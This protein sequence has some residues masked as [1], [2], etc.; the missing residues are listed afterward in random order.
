MSRVKR[1]IDSKT[2]ENEVDE[3]TETKTKKSQKKLNKKANKK[4]DKKPKNR[5][6]DA[7]KVSKADTNLSEVIVSEKADKNKS[8]SFKNSKVFKKSKGTVDAVNK[9]TP[10]AISWLKRAG[11]NVIGVVDDIAKG[12]H[13]HI[14]TKQLLMASGAILLMGYGWHLSNAA[15]HKNLKTASYDETIFNKHNVSSFTTSGTTV[16]STK[17]YK[18]LDGK[19]TYLPLI[20]SN[21]TT[22][23][24]PRDATQMKTTIK[25]AGS[26]VESSKLSAEMVGYPGLNN[27]MFYVY[28]VHKPNNK[29]QNVSSQF[30]TTVTD[31]L[32]SSTTK[33]ANG[34]VQK[35]EPDSLTFTVDLGSKKAEN[36]KSNDD[37]ANLKT[38]FSNTVFKENAKTIIDRAN[39]TISSNAALY[40]QSDA[41]LETLSKANVKV[42]STPQFATR[43]EVGNVYNVNYKSN[44][45]KGYFPQDSYDQ[46]K[47]QYLSDGYTDMTSRFNIGM[48]SSI[49][50][51]LTY[52]DGKQIPSSDSTTL[53]A[54]RDL[55]NAWQTIISNKS[56]GYVSSAQQLFTL[57]YQYDFN[58][59]K[60]TQ[61]GNDHFKISA[62]TPN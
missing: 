16:T 48:D 54:A 55:G 40:N 43:D 49:L 19:T 56:Q 59:T 4:S 35:I 51:N 62:K 46:L 20:F 23:Q 13:H 21:G 28:I 27:D 18:S 1:K 39:D 50:S 36:L 15:Y 5:K 33:D 31:N 38:M 22:A 25:Y 14:L 3:I 6:K 26:I 53:T 47:R 11:S 32:T 52:T 37:E 45:V 24:M 44:F 17:L 60:P 61:S 57:Q 30:T 2:V 10:A 34:K 42:P 12:S 8:K 9:R 7:R 41:L 29:Y 58:L